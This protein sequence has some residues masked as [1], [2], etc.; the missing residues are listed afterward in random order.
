MRLPISCSVGRRAT[1]QARRAPPPTRHRTPARCQGQSI[2]LAARR[3][4]AAGAS[5]HAA[6]VRRVRH[7]SRRLAPVQREGE[8][9]GHR[10]R[11][12]L[13]AR[14]GGHERTGSARSAGARGSPPGTRRHRRRPTDGPRPW[15]SSCPRVRGDRARAARGGLHVMDGSARRSTPGRGRRRMKK[16]TTEDDGHGPPVAATRPPWPPRPRPRAAA[17][18][19]H[20]T[21]RHERGERQLGE[22][23]DGDAAARRAADGTAHDQPCAGQ[24]T[25][26]N[27]SVAPAC[28]PSRSRR[29]SPAASRSLYPRP[30]AA[31]NAS[32]ARLW[33]R[34]SAVVQITAATVAAGR[35]TPGRAQ[36]IPQ[37][38]DG[39]RRDGEQ[40]QSAGRVFKRPPWP[41]GPANVIG[42]QRVKAG[43]GDDPDPPR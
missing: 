18:I 33:P 3:L 30:H 22:R 5:S 39:Q 8:P 38:C 42:E 17:T 23:A 40:A 14:A 13:R 25:A 11:A 16:I 28:A 7:S 12:P 36:H 1:Q 31:A 9:P 32:S 41:P 19:H 15:R 6:P 24:P 2:R 20:A 21:G 29:R 43:R 27:V 34:A 4:P 37:Q 35:I 10:S 26:S